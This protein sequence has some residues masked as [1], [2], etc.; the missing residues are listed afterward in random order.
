MPD[1]NF[2]LGPELLP[3]NLVDLKKELERELDMRRRVYPE[4]V[5]KRRLSPHKAR[6]QCHALKKAMDV[7]DEIERKGIE[8]D[9]LK[10]A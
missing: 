10:G 7:L 2:G 5:W 4:Y 1:D 8:L 3:V 6:F 9:A